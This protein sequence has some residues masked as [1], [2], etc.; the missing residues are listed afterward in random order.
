MKYIKN[1]KIIKKTL[2][3]Y[4][5]NSYNDVRLSVHDDNTERKEQ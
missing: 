1:R 5:T 3:D 4:K 2:A